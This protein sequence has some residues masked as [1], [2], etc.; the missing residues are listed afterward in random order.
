[1]EFWL[2]Q[3]FTAIDRFEPALL[4]NR[5]DATGIRCGLRNAP[6]SQALPA[7]PLNVLSGDE[8]D[9]ESL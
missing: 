4:S 6:Q 7:T 1:M 9:A 8:N 3:A 5:L 2:K